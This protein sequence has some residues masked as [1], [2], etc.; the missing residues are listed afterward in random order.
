[1]VKYMTYQQVVISSGHGKY[2]RGAAGVL[3]EVD[4]ARKV[5]EQVAIELKNR[6]V[7]V[8]TFH[9]DTSHSQNE[10]LNT[11]VNFHNG[12]DRN[13]DISVHFNAYVE[14]TKAM[15]TEVLY[16]TQ[17][18][19]ASQMSSAIASAGGFLN[20]GAKK[21]TDLFFL[22]NTDEPAILLEVCFVDSTVDAD[23][24]NANFADICDA[25]ASV[26]GGAE[27]ESAPPNPPVTSEAA[28]VDITVAT[29]GDVKVTINGNEVDIDNR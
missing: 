26:L 20:R 22:N 29:T 6:G 14:T 15:G 13:L 1:M 5:V 21:R 16:V 19:L 25:I 27:N 18:S 17:Q 24:Y 11:I 23:L 7:I 28:T 8:T 3:D 2:I 4:E 12:N 9:D 10:N